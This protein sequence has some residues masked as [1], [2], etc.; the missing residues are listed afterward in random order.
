MPTRTSIE[1]DVLARI[2]EDTTGTRRV[3]HLNNAG[4]ALMP[5]PVVD[6]V[7]AHLRREEEIGGYEAHAESSARVEGVYQ[8][9]AQVVGA[10]TREIALADSATLAWQRVFYSLPFAAGDRILTTRGEFAANYVAYL[11]VAKKYGVVVDIIPDDATGALDVHALEGIIDDRVRLISI[12]WVP[13]NGGLI[14]AAAEVGRI[15]RKYGITYLLDACQAVGQLPIDVDALNCDVLTATGRKFLR[16][17]RGTG[18]AYIRESLLSELE[19]AFI[20]LFGAPW[21]GPEQYQLRDDARR[22]ETWENN[23]A[24]RLGL[25]VAAEYALGIGLDEIHARNVL[26]TSHLRDQLASINGV[27]L[28]DKGTEFAAIVSIT[29]DRIP[30]QALKVS[31]GD[32]GI[33]VSV[34]PPSTTPLDATDRGLPD[35]LRISPHYYNTVDEID[36]FVAAL[37]KA[38]R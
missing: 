31:L 16:A 38:L 27:H 1:G 14:N 24:T 13:S 17:P 8:S 29:H 10:N 12:T 3:N 34:S 15:A 26:L 19:P 22:F 35:V 4:A 11:Q 9:V 28:K 18:F 37:R 30:A 32:A 33:N 36:H 23:Y 5:R 25:G 20:D 21:V 2:R 7:T 6:A